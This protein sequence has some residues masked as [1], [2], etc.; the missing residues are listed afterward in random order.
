[1]EKSFFLM[2]LT[3]HEGKRLPY[4]RITIGQAVRMHR[5][6]IAVECDGDTKKA[7]LRADPED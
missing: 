6:G 5:L 1:M 7:I 2:W 3:A 4:S